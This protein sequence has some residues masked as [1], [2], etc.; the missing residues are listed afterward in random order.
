MQSNTAIHSVV[1]A[2]TLSTVAAVSGVCMVRGQVVCCVVH[3]PV[4]SL[5]LCITAPDVGVTIHSVMAH[6]Q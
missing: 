5:G 6:L 3:I 4:H 1:C 2:D